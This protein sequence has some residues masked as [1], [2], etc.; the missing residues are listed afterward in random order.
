M[1]GGPLGCGYWF[2]MFALWKTSDAATPHIVSTVENRRKQV[3]R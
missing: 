2:G 1:E 3:G